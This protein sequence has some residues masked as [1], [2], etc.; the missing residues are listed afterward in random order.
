MQWPNGKEF[1]FSVFDDT[2]GATLETVAGVYELLY[3]LKL[4][5]TKSVWVYPPR[6]RFSGQSLLDPPYLEWILQLQA[7]G[8]EI[9]LHNV[10][11]GRF[12]REEILT[13]LDLFKN[14]LGHYPRIHSNHENNL[15]NIYWMNERF[16]WPF[17][18]LYKA[19]YRYIERRD[20]VALGSRPGS[21]C[22]WGDACKLHID[23]IRNYTCRNVNTLAFNPSMPYLDGRKAA[24]A[25]RWFSSS[26]G[27]TVEEF[28]DLVRPQALEQLRSEG[29]ACIVYTHFASGFVDGRGQLAPLFRTRMEHL[30]SLNGWFVPASD[31]LDHLRSR[32]DAPLAHRRPSTGRW[33]AD[34]LVK[35]L[36]YGR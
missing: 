2:D 10:G 26:D 13:G 23:Y 5:T 17:N 8:F 30:A 4:F 31:L 14:L 21:P 18:Q 12:S 24:F 28:C 7:R 9:G 36:R 25:N 11:D 22:F 15:D 33:L 6:G 32:Q 16:D 34:R 20:P 1:A 3:E 27:H 35:K 29:G 19:Y